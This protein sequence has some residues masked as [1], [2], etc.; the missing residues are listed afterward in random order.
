MQNQLPV[1]IKLEGNRMIDTSKVTDT[2][3]EDV[4]LS[5]YPDFCDAYIANAT[6]D[7]REITEEELEE[8]NEDRDFIYEAAME[9]IS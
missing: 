2:E 8:L 9:S 3:I 7:G 5:D 6:Y 1:V 4:M